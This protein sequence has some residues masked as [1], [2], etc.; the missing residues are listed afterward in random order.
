MVKLDLGSEEEGIVRI[1]T[2][3]QS[4]SEQKQKTDRQ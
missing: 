4:L 1:L 2:M 3:E